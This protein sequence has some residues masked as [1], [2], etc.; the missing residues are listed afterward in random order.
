MLD[1]TT[2]IDNFDGYTQV[3]CTI[4]TDLQQ[5]AKP[6]QV[7]NCS[8][9]VPY[10]DSLKEVRLAAFLEL[11]SFLTLSLSQIDEEIAKLQQ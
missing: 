6:R 1:L 9:E 3:H 2:S 5:I 10:A 7:I 11:K 8:I 4:M